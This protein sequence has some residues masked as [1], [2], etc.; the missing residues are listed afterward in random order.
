LEEKPRV[1]FGR[2]LVL[3]EKEPGIPHEG[4]NGTGTRELKSPLN[5]NLKSKT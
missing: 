1:Y 4:L 3:V 2:V 5:N